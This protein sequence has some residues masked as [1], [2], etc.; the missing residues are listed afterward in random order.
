MNIK[1]IDDLAWSIMLHNEEYE[2]LN[3][4]FAINGIL[5]SGY[6]DK[7]TIQEQN[8]ITQCLAIGIQAF[9]AQIKQTIEDH[10]SWRKLPPIKISGNDES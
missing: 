5:A 3:R 4:V 10:D 1:E 7:L 2:E 8:E 9:N 6:F